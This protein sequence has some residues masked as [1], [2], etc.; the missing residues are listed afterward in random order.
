MLLATSIGIGDLSAAPPWQEKKNQGE[1]AEE[2]VV[3]SQK[4][5]KK[6][7]SDLT[8]DRFLR[9]TYK[10]EDKKHT[11]P[12]SLETA[13]VRYTKEGV[14]ADK[15]HVDLVGAVHVGD[16]AYY[17]KLNKKF[18][19][20]DV[21]LYELVAPKGTRIPKGGREEA[22]LHP[23]GALQNG[24]KSV[25]DLKHQLNFIDYMADNLVHADMSP[26]EFNKSMADR[27]ESFGKMMFRSMGHS[28]AKQAAGKSQSEVALIMSLFSSNRT[29][30]LKRTLSKEFES[31]ESTMI[32]F[33]GEGGS[34]IISERNKKALEE[35]TLQLKKGKTKIAIFYGAAHLPDMEER[36]L[37]EFKLTLGTTEWVEAWDMRDPPKKEE[38]K[39]G[40]NKKS[41]KKERLKLL[42]K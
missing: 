30:S 32:V 21:V 17:E 2:K 33:E 10:K 16:E 18:T 23:I 3:Q 29:L 4:R 25:L 1:G 9:L 11:K 40:S 36:L 38:G 27:D 42:E 13:I 22:N 7:L 19:E 24:M 39:K 37:N 5:A 6:E 15:F 31:L 20:Y 26:T 8:K 41:E 12:Q 14:A 28:M 34:T 35:L